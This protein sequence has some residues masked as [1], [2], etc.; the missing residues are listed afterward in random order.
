MIYKAMSHMTLPYMCKLST[1]PTL[2]AE[3]SGG[4]FPN[5]PHIR[6]RECFNF[7][8]QMMIKTLKSFKY[9][10]LFSYIHDFSS[11][12]IILLYHVPS[13]IFLSLN[14]VL[15]YAWAEVRER[16]KIVYS[17]HL[18]YYKQSLEH[19]FFSSIYKFLLYQGYS[20][21]VMR[22]FRMNWKL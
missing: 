7:F 20:D 21:S 12:R 1:V 3:I 22:Y 15:W 4:Y 9:S 13:L 6:L 10:L 19:T 18:R 16:L 14:A 5:I 17:I 2:V 8:I 11:E